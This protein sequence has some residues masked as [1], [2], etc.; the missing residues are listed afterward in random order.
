[1]N[2]YLTRRTVILLS[3][4]FAFAGIA[5]DVAPPTPPSFGKPGEAIFSTVV[6]LKHPKKSEDRAEGG[7][8]HVF[9]TLW[10]PDGVKAVRG[11]HLTPFNLDTVEKQQSRAF[12]RHWGFAIVGG[13]FMRVQRDDF[14]PALLDGL[15]DL[16]TKSGHGEIAH[17]PMILTSMS[18][19]V[20][21]CVTLAEQL[22]ERVIACG[23][24]CLQ[25]GPET[26]RTRDVPMMSLFGE[27]DGPQMELHEALLPKRRAA[28]DA[29]WAITPQWGRKHEWGL[30][31]NL[32][33]PFLDEVIR[34]RLPADASPADG[35]V[36]LR[37]YDPARVWLGDPAS[38]R[39]RA[40]T[41]A[42][43]EKYPGDKSAAC[44]LPGKD[45]ARVWQAFAVNK[46]L[47]RI[48]SPLPQGGGNPLAIFAPG[49]DVTVQVQCDTA[50]PAQKITL[51]DRATRLA[52]A[53]VRDGKC[54]LRIAN[55][56]P[57][58][59]TFIAHATTADGA[60]ELSRPVTI[61]IASPATN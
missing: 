11:I 14:A 9:F 26:E 38:W 48:T 19:G 44:W 34:Q 54:E 45:V 49:A 58:P 1:M 13:N 42:P 18:A 8:N 25:I 24:A 47:V 52:E 10:I 41:I 60:V 5:Q 31:N 37:R 32:L 59:H 23:L 61:L 7:A 4:V 12:A 36:T 29:S 39:N 50:F 43:L 35:P 57:G 20:G 15:R 46:P 6:A 33:W 21:M 3:L 30:A 28:F 17:A 27:R 51:Y 22:P 56:T 53:D 55:L 2:T 16:A 40:A